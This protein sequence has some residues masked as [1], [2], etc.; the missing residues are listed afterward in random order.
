ME[1]YP[2]IRNLQTRSLHSFA[3]KINFL[4]GRSAEAD[5][6]LHDVSC[7]RQQFHI[8]LVD[9]RWMLE[10]L[11]VTSPTTL[12]GQTLTG[13]VQLF[14]G[15]QIEA[16]NSIFCFLLE[17]ERV[18]QSL[19]GLFNN[20]TVFPKA[21]LQDFVERNV[22]QISGGIVDDF[23]EKFGDIPLKGTQIIGRE[24]G[25]ADIL[26]SHPQ[27]S[28]LHAQ[29]IVNSGKATVA[30]LNS[31]NG[32]FHNGHRIG[33]PVSLIVGDRIDI[34]PYS[35]VFKGNYFQ[36]QTRDNNIELIGM[37]L[38]KKI[39]EPGTGLEITLLDQISLVVHPHE[40]VGILGPSG[41]GKST[42]LGA[43]SA[44]NPA[45]TGQVLI[46]GKSL[47]SSLDSMRRDLVV[48]PQKDLHF[49]SLT[50]EESL[51]YTGKL[52]LPTDIQDAE[53][54]L[55]VD[56]MLITVGLMS[57]KKSVI[58][59]LSGGQLKRFS[60]A[61]ELIS[62][63]TLIFLDEVTSGLDQQTD[64]EIMS[65]CRT[66][67]ES[68]KT[69]LCVTHNLANVVQFCH[70]IV[71]LA[72]GGKMAFLGAPAEAL[73]FFGIKNL[74]DI[75]EKLQ[76]R[77]PEDWQE[78]YQKSAIFDRYIGLR[79]PN[80]SIENLPTFGS[81]KNNII[82][83][84][85]DFFCQSKVLV[86]RYATIFLSDR[87]NLLMLAFN[88]FLIAFLFS[89]LFGNIEL[90]KGVIEK[91]SR[92]FNLNFMVSVF[93]FW[94]GCNNAAR[95]FVRE[96]EIFHREVYFN[97]N[98]ISYYF[99]KFLV[100]VAITLS[101]TFLL[102]F[103]VFFLCHP[104]I[105]FFI[106]PLV[107]F[108]LSIVGVTVGLAISASAHSTE[109]AASTVPLVLIPQ[110]I[111]G[112]VLQPLNGVAKFLGQTIISVFWGTKALNSTFSEII[113]DPVPDSPKYSI[114]FSTL[115]LLIH[116]S[117]FIFIGL[118]FLLKSCKIDFIKIAIT[119]VLNAFKK[120]AKLH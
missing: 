75:Y 110:I 111:L 28:R 106:T 3:G 18:P 114:Y 55:V 36:P 67:A 12:N 26:L 98:V 39:T 13:S 34:G 115:A 69:L 72:P 120:T 66:L 45:D 49:D 56:Q 35:L 37:K 70:L 118:Y 46:N 63:P 99:S 5:L 64:R 10:G 32:T 107:L 48:V 105:S 97:L 54:N 87:Y 94:F 41:S 112:D 117:V 86:H 16:G 25:R 59:T 15:T 43:L 51:K 80:E 85:N 22:T 96:R 104:P 103:L 73:P 11:S 119:L 83:L 7:S 4:I 61:T 101:Q 91:S 50:V 62:K 82:L 90:K 33:Q 102:W 84:I 24:M 57:K 65:L 68:G 88:V 20:V 77:T 44:R 2:A 47:Y 108:L 81:P 109:A 40:F 42:L 27:V 100:L 38:S 92:A 74:S 89:I 1:K 71:I 93:V 23:Q 21:P 78:S 52:R 95:E 30:D 9:D 116:A 6:A 76:E 31:A 60:L 17:P 8:F 53:L 58:R 29:I 79:L 113:Q 19:P 14:H